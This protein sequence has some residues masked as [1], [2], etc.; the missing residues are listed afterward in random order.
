MLRYLLQFLSYDESDF[1]H[2]ES[3]NDGS[4]SR[5]NGT[6][7]FLFCFDY[8]VGRVDYSVGSVRGVASSVFFPIGI[9]SNC[10]VVLLVLFVT[11]GVESKGG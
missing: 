2:Y 9:K 4:E 5:S 10:D 11:I 7:A 8:S 6:C 1:L 3:D